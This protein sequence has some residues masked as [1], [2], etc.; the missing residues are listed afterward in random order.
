MTTI[1]ASVASMHLKK[2]FH[3]RGLRIALLS[4]GGI[5]LASPLLPASS[6]V[7][8]DFSSV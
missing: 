3:V 6:L 2:V 8:V 5:L 4:Q 1:A 7:S